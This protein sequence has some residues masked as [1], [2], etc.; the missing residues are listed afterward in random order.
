MGDPLCDA[1]LETLFPT[2]TS[3]VGKDLL[4]SLEQYVAD[5]PGRNHASVFLD[6]VS[7]APPA[8]IQAS[9]EQV[10]LGQAFFLDYAIQIMQALLHYSLAAGFARYASPYLTRKNRLER[11]RQRAHRAHSPGS[12]IS[13]PAAEQGSP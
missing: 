1:A 11:R 8:G 10:E 6:E 5:N 12:I 7:Q 13:R 3:S 4:A 2:A 9:E